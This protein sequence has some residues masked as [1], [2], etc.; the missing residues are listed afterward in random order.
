MNDGITVVT[1][2]THQA[3]KHGLIDVSRQLNDVHVSVSQ[4]VHEGNSLFSV[5]SSQTDE[6]S[7]LG[8]VGRLIESFGVE[9]V[10]PTN[11]SVDQFAIDHVCVYTVVH[12]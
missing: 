2:K 6:C 7:L 5:N 8:S 3:F 12:G 10:K 4:L 11:D 9:V 1:T